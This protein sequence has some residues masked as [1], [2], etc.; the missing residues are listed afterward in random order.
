MKNF[1]AIEI[2]PIVIK[3]LRSRMRGVRAF[4]ILSLVL[5]LLGVFSFGLYRIVTTAES[6]SS[7]PLS[8]QVGQVL[9]TG[10][11]F[12]EL[13]L[14]AA[15]TP[16]LTSGAISDEKENQTYEILC[17]TPINPTRIL[18]GKLGS[19]L[20][21]IFI[22][23]FAA[24]PISSLVF[25]FGGVSYRDMI[26]AILLLSA[27]AVMVGVIGIFTSALFGRT[28]RATAVTYLI[29]VF[30]FLGPVFISIIVGLFQQHEISHWVLIQS[31][32]NALASAISPSTGFENRSNLIW[33]FG[34]TPEWLFGSQIISFTSIPRPLYHYS[35]PLFGF[36]TLILF[37]ISTRLVKPIFRWKIQW[38]EAILALAI[39]IGY[40]GLVLLAF[41]L[42]A[43]R[44]E[45]NRLSGRSDS[46]PYS[47][48]MCDLAVSKSTHASTDDQPSPFQETNAHMHGFNSI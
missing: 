22:V 19:S 39:I 20:G 32:L 26:K 3:E 25:V 7:A 29:V 48:E 2:N 38:T 21:Y 43:H 10:L 9:F 17:A 45:Y 34:S 40:M 41:T 4:V 5:I 46:H 6:Y 23:I 37:L 44:Y 35:L 24:L 8:P 36:I 33:R 16:T 31:P 30:L 27:V 15:I 11:V 47:K 28:G 14:I 12:L 42:T 18:W 13:I 1:G